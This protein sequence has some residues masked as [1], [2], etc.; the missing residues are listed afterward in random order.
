M[1]CLPARTAHEP[2]PICAA[3][4]VFLNEGPGREGMF[5]RPRHGEL[6]SFLFSRDGKSTTQSASVQEQMNQ[7]PQLGNTVL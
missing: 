1:V 3:D 7:G 2:E 6:H 5:H 4:T